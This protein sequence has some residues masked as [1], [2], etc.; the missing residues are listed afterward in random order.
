M[1]SFTAVAGFAML[2]ENSKFSAVAGFAM[3]GENSKFYSSC[4]FLQCWERIQ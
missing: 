1:V 3:L 4:R 2:G